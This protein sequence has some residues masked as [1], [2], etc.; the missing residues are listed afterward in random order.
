MID[1]KI[2]TFV[3]DRSSAEVCSAMRHVTVLHYQ[4]KDSLDGNNLACIMTLPPFQRKG[5]GK[6]L[7]AFSECVAI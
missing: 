3:S 1:R 4:E 6:F 2:V 7:I 5:Y